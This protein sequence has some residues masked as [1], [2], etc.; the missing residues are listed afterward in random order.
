MVGPVQEDAAAAAQ[1]QLG[2]VLGGLEHA[3]AGPEGA[4][5]DCACGWN[6]GDGGGERQIWTGE[7]MPLRPQVD[8]R[9]AFGSTLAAQ[10]RIDVAVLDPRAS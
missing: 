9:G 2:C 5:A 7:V 4:V 3:G 10:R 8:Q 1:A 6:A